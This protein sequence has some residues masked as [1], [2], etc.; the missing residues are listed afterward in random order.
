MQGSVA[1]RLRAEG[2]NRTASEEVPQD[3]WFSDWQDSGDL[4]EISRHYARFDQTVSLL[5]FDEDELPEIKPRNGRNSSRS[6]G[7]RGVKELTGE[8]PWPGRSRRKR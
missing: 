7:E 3:L 1:H 5:W 8:L 4:W 6:D 2:L